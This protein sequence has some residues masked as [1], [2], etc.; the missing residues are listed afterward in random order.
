LAT[1][2]GKGAKGEVKLKVKEEEKEGD[3]EKDEGEERVRSDKT[4]VND[5]TM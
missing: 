1:L 2:Y 4:I 5:L 3:N